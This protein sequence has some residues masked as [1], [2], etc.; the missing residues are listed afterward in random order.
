MHPYYSKN[1]GIYDV[2]IT[3]PKVSPNTD[4]CDPES[5]D[6]VDYIGVR[7]SVG[8]DAIAIKAL[9]DGKR[10]AYP[11]CI[12]GTNKM[13]FHFVS[14]LDELEKGTFGIAEPPETNERFSKR[15]SGCV[16]CLVPALAYDKF[17]YRIGYGKGFYDRYLS[18][19]SGCTLGVVYSDYILPTVPR[20]RYDVSVNILLT[21]KG[22]KM[23]GEN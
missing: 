21:E 7:F 12:P 17:G 18:G 13:N 14:S 20:G 23:T 6:G 15:S 19:F 3:A 22:V 10:V 4:A 2:A 8:D 9:E 5:C 16:V 11:R 1:V